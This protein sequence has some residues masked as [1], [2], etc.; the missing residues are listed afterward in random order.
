MKNNIIIAGII[1]I[2]IGVALFAVG[3]NKMQPTKTEKTIGL[4]SDFTEGVI[5]EK[6]EGIPTRNKSQHII[7]IISG[8]LSFII[9]L[10]MI[11]KSER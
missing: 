6:I 1:L 3:Y 8:G 4:I 7:M 11:L 9:G 2:I 5:G 10:I